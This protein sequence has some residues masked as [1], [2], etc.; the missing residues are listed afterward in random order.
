MVRRMF[1]WR[2]TALAA[3]LV[4][5]A[6]GR[7]GGPKADATTAVQSFLQSV[8][9]GDS[10]AFEAKIDRPALRADL[11]RQLRDVGHGRELD[12]D[13]GPSD[14]ALDRMIDPAAFRLVDVRTGAALAGPPNAA[15]AAALIKPA[16]KDHVCLHDLTPAANCLLVFA[17]AP[18]AKGQKAEDGAA[19]WRLVHMPMQGAAIAVAPPP[20]EKK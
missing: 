6:C 2:T 14:A 18:Q 1:R 11:R 3:L 16:D 5:S 12:V 7:G 15:Q 19:G 4:L 13:G 17:H 9:S 10:A 20:A 8:Q